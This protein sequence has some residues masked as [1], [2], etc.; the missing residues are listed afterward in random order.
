MKFQLE[1][2]G[3]NNKDLSM[4]LG[5][6]SLLEEKKRKRKRKRKKK[7]LSSMSSL[8]LVILSFDLALSPLNVIVLM[9]SLLGNGYGS[10]GPPNSKNSKPTRHFTE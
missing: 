2:E 1:I 3:P 4:T 9:A 8:L 7:R 5:F 10:T 6:F